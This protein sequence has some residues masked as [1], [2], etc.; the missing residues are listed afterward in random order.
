MIATSSTD[1][2]PFSGV[3]S[4]IT[5]SQ[6]KT[7]VIAVGFVLL[8]S[9]SLS[10]AVVNDSDT[11]S[12]LKSS[13]IN[14]M[15][16]VSDR[17]TTRLG[18]SE[19]GKW[20][21]QLN[22]NSVEYV[23]LD[24]HDSSSHTDVVRLSEDEDLGRSFDVIGLPRDEGFIFL[25]KAMEILGLTSFFCTSAVPCISSDL[26]ENTEYLTV[27][28]YTNAS[29]EKSLELDSFLTRKLITTFARLPERLSFAV[30]ETDGNN[31]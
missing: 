30:Y 10:H 9:S 17:T 24:V 23:G 22:S 21:D 26:E 3:T 14:K 16:L 20:L 12:F 13:F 4:F 11:T 19:Y 28:L 1:Y 25:N 31:S 6:A 5:N 29:F 2:S 7:P 27:R 18:S 15:M 8:L